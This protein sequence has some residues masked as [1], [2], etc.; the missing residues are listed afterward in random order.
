VGAVRADR[1]DDPAGGLQPEA[2]PHPG[3]DEI[4]RRVRPGRARRIAR[5]GRKGAADHGRHGGR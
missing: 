5:F 2:G 4:G 3:D 1:F